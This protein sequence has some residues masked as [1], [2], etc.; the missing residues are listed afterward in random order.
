M[1]IDIFITKRKLSDAILDKMRLFVWI[2][3]NYFNMRSIFYS[4]IEW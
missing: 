2:C 1:K 4:L 3:Q